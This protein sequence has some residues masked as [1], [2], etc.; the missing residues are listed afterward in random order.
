MNNEMMMRWS[1]NFDERNIFVNIISIFH[2]KSSQ[3]LNNTALIVSFYISISTKFLMMTMQLRFKK[4]KTTTK[5]KEKILF[6]HFFD[7]IKWYFLHFSSFVAISTSLNDVVL[8]YSSFFFL[9]SVSLNW[10]SSLHHHNWLLHKEQDERIKLKKE[11]FLLYIYIMCPLF[12]VL[13]YLTLFPIRIFFS[14]AVQIS[15]VNIKKYQT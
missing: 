12:Y 15:D 4:K 6:S 3:L 1:F 5:N 13:P 11:D 2:S 8:C 14:W 7:G 10:I 9:F